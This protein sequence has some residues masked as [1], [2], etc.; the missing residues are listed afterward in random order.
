MKPLQDQKTRGNSTCGAISHV[1]V[2]LNEDDSLLP[3]EEYS[4]MY[5]SR[6]QCPRPPRRKPN[7]QLAFGVAASLLQ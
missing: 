2:C 6:R 3:R 5:S 7:L 1:Y 4:A